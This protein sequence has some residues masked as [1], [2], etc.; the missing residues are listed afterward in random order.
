VGQKMKPELKG[1]PS[2]TSLSPQQ[3]QIK[4][5]THTYTEGM[6]LLPGHTYTYIP[7]VSGSTSNFPYFFKNLQVTG[8]FSSRMMWTI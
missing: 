4:L 1:A 2:L 3:M 8:L 6:Y 5:Y 7:Y